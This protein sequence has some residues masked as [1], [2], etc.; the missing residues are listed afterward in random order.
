MFGQQRNNNINQTLGHPHCDNNY[1]TLSG[2]AEYAIMYGLF[3]QE[4]STKSHNMSL[5]NVVDH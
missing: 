2:N 4:P 1:A 3:M 5:K